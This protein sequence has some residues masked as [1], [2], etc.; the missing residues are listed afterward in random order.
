MLSSHYALLLDSH[1]LLRWLVLLA[2]VAVLIGSVI[3]LSRHLPFK[4]LGRVLGLIYVSLLDIQF[5]IGLL[6]CF[7]S[8][9]VHS[10]W[11]NPAVGM[12][13]HHLRFFAVEHPA[14]MILALIVAHLGAVVSK[15]AVT[16]T[17]AYT[18]AL[19]CYGASFALILLGIP[20]WRPFIRI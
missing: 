14:G 7:A 8:P 5:L 11:A 2:G 6:L 9:I 4:P 1:S 3:G 10:V 18:N 15:K 17:K 12:K 13:V 19:V 16:D 20:W